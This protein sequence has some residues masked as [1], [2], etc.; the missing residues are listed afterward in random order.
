MEV[1]KFSDEFILCCRWCRFYD[2]ELHERSPQKATQVILADECV[3]KIIFVLAT[4]FSLL[5]A[6]DLL[7]SGN[8]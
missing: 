4:L 8:L 7:R 6:D 3:L 1:Y 5:A 2:L